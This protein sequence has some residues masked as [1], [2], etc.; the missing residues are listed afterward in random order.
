MRSSNTMASVMPSVTSGHYRSD[1][2]C[3]RGV[4]ALV[5]AAANALKLVETI[6]SQSVGKVSREEIAQEMARVLEEVRKA[7]DHDVEFLVEAELK[8]HGITRSGDERIRE[9]PFPTIPVDHDETRETFVVEENPAPAEQP[10]KPRRIGGPVLP[11]FVEVM[12]RPKE[13]FGG[14][15]K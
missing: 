13:S 4:K 8:K 5:D 6:R 15:G 11:R 12:S 10:A 9:V 1:P 3:R 7:R 14:L 2:Y